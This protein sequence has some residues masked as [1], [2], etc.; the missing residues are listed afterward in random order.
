M[1]TV[2]HVLL[3]GGLWTACT[4]HHEYDECRIPG[5]CL[6]ENSARFCA[7]GKD[8]DE[9]GLID[10]RDPSCSPFCA[11][12]SADL[13]CD[14]VDNDGNGLIDCNDPHCAETVTC[15]ENDVQKCTDEVD[16]NLDGHTDCADLE[17]C[18]VSVCHNLALCSEELMRDDFQSG[19]LETR[20]TPFQASAGYRVAQNQISVD[21]KGLNIYN[22]AGCYTYTEETGVI[23]NQIFD[24]SKGR[25]YIEAD[26]EIENHVNLYALDVP[27]FM[28]LIPHK[29][30]HKFIR[31]YGIRNPPENRPC[32]FDA[33]ISTVDPTQLYETALLFELYQDGRRKIIS[34]RGDE[35]HYFPSMDRELPVSQDKQI[36]QTR[37][38]LDDQEIVFFE[39]QQDTW[40]ELY[41][42][43]NPFPGR[44]FHLAFLGSLDQTEA[45]LEF[46]VHRVRV[47]QNRHSP[48]WQTRYADTFDSDPKWETNNP[49][50]CHHDPEHGAMAVIWEAMS[51]E[52]CFQP[53][54]PPLDGQSFRLEYSFFVS[55]LEYAAL[56]RPGLFDSAAEMDNSFNVWAGPGQPM[57]GTIMCAQACT[58]AGK[59]YV[60]SSAVIGTWLTT[61]IYYDT[62]Q[63]RVQIE[64]FEAQT[65]ETIFWNLFKEAGC[66]MDF[67]YFGLSALNRPR[68]DHEQAHGLVDDVELRVMNRDE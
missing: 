4:I 19:G 3:A 61:R 54:D 50:H 34:R 2:F 26:L 40:Q 23:S 45:D 20:W 44:K 30:S 57:D 46:W 52:Y 18:L 14:D 17:C 16:N 31:R 10:C 32:P 29:Q 47:S 48:H 15:L 27:A 25:L 22:K 60:V 33:P 11:E 42:I 43:D 37:Y 63:D 12:N 41:R 38:D 35:K 36:W 53:L 5:R 59:E 62:P 67:Y 7:D 51:E 13:C 55:A 66:V 9:D 6:Y 39:K 65:E 8:N 58:K 28:A 1:A 56:F 24:L 68:Y 64:V 21:E 49:D